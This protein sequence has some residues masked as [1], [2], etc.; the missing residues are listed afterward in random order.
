[1]RRRL[2]QGA[3]LLVPRPLLGRALGTCLGAEGFR[4]GH[5]V[6][7]V[8][9]AAE[10]AARALAL[11]GRE[12]APPRTP[13]PRRG[14]EELRAV[15]ELGDVHGKTQGAERLAHAHGRRARRGLLRG[16]G[17]L[18]RRLRH[19]GEAPAVLVGGHRRARRVVVG[20][21]AAASPGS[22]PSWLAR[23]DLKSLCVYLVVDVS[24][25]HPSVQPV[26]SARF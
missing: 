14:R 13:R 12:H 21:A 3:G 9:V 10:E 11:G 17:V 24:L 20:V 18:G 5:V 25:L 6:R 22:M 26:P 2:A 7:I 15:A 19:G 8:G 4:V 23:V 1:V 16:G